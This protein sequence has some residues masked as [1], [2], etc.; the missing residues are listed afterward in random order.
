MVICKLTKSGTWKVFQEFEY[1]DI[2]RSDES[3]A[4]CPKCGLCVDA[5]EYEE[6]HQ[7][8]ILNEGNK[9]ER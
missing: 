1:R 5:R 3:I 2:S 7:S 4:Y 8:V 6:T 9:Y